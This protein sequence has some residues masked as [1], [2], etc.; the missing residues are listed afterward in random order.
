VKTQGEKRKV[1]N[2]GC[3]FR[4]KK[5]KKNRVTYLHRRREQF[6]QKR[7]KKKRAK[8]KGKRKWS[9]EG[10]GHNIYKN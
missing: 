10:E 2:P 4:K 3:E 7:I 8:R 9:R 5:V 6:L 1:P